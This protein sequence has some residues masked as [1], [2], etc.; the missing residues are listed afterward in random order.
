LFS[1]EYV[2]DTADGDFTGSSSTVGKIV[3]IVGFGRFL[4]F[5]SFNTKKVKPTQKEPQRIVTKYKF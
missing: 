4:V 3:D 1:G 2:G 5:Y